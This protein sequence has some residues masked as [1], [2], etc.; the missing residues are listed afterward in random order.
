MN[1]SLLNSPWF[2]QPALHPDVNCRCSYCAQLLV[3][4][5]L[6]QPPFP[7]DGE[8]LTI[9]YGWSLYRSSSSPA[10]C[11][12]L[13]FLGI[14]GVELFWRSS[15]PLQTSVWWRKVPKLLATP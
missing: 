3:V 7:R 1:L 11:R 15:A 6:S 2:T 10:H 13:V 12:Y 9:R 8:V 14:P 4:M 5:P